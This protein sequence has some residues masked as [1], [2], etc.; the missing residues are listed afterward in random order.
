MTP[1]ASYL[2]ILSDPGQLAMVR[3]VQRLADQVGYNQKLWIDTWKEH[4]L[5]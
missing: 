1:E 4:I 3:Q 5:R 2:G